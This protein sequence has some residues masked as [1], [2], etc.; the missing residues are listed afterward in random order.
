VKLI[1]ADAIPVNVQAMAY[2]AKAK[3]RPF[4][5]VNMP[6]R[7]VKTIPT[8]IAEKGRKLG[9][10]EQRSKMRSSAFCSKSRVQ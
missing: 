6:I 8:A 7:P 5:A 2:T 10:G 9:I 1:T 4:F 3:S